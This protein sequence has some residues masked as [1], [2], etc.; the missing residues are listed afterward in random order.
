M[1]RYQIILKINQKVLMTKDLKLLIFID[2]DSVCIN[3]KHI[4]ID[5]PFCFEP[6][7]Y[8]SEISAN[9]TC[10]YFIK[11]TLKEKIKRK[12]FLWRMNREIKI[13]FVTNSSST[14]YICLDR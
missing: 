7:G 10:K 1:I 3:C 13:D 2:P 14:S 5:G 9:Y 6:D 8:T 11:Q 4:D 12:Y